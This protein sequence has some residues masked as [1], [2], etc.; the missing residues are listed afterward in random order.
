MGSG[1][2]PGVSRPRK[3]RHPIGGLGPSSGKTHRKHLE[4]TMS[5]VKHVCSM[6][7]YKHMQTK[8]NKTLAW[9]LEP[10]AEVWTPP[11]MFGERG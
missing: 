1:A 3:A 8:R 4:K 10:K 6:Y 2:S 7:V 5:W 11:G 9:K